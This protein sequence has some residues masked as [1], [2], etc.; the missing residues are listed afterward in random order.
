MAPDLVHVPHT[1]RNKPTAARTLR[2]IPIGQTYAQRKLL[3]K[4][5]YQG[6]R[7]IRTLRIYMH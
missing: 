6:R 5:Y 4:R 1:V 2:Y 3:T 7:L